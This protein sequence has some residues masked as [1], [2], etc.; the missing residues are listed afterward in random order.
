MSTQVVYLLCLASHRSSSGSSRN[1]DYR[2]R[3]LVSIPPC[4]RLEMKLIAAPPHA[5]ETPHFQQNTGWKSL[6]L[7]MAQR[8]CAK[9]TNAKFTHLVVWLEG[10]RGFEPSASLSVWRGSTLLVQY[11]RGILEKFSVSF[12]PCV[13]L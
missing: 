4:R 5:Q 2:I 10:L 1:R 6:H 9:R 12:L 11:Q 8:F 7:M 3:C 13:R